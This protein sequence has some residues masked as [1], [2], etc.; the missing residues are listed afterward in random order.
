MM[1]TMM[2]MLGLSSANLKV[3]G[4]CQL[5][6]KRRKIFLSCP[7]TFLALQVQSIVLVSASVWSVQFDN[8]LVFCSSYS[9]CPRALDGVS[10]IFVLQFH[11]RKHYKTAIKSECIVSQ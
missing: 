1:M 4:T 9:R 5:G 6:A 10:V 7:S 8:F 2:T 3:G 11:T